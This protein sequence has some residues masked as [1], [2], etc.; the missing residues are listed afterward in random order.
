MMEEVASGEWQVARENSYESVSKESW[1]ADF[2]AA[3][4][5]ARLMFLSQCP[6]REVPV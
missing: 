1:L 3:S 2:I 6:S 4:E 5:Q